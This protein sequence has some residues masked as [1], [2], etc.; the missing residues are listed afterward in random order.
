MKYVLVMTYVRMSDP[1]QNRVIDAAHANG[2]PVSSHELYP[3]VAFGADHVEH[4]R[5]TSRRGYSPKISALSR[6]Y[7][8]VVALLAASGMTLT[9]TMGL[10]GGFWYLVGRDSSLLDDPRVL[11]IYTQAYVDRLIQMSTARGGGGSSDGMPASL[12]AQ[13]E[14]IKGIVSGGG[15]VIAGTDSPIIPNCRTTSTGG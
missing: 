13:G 1:M 3:A 4:I 7:Q 8:D 14:T 15:R 5:G 9:P 11:A 12:V 10:Q 6:S 2:I